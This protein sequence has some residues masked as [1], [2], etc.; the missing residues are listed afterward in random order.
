L[1]ICSTEEFLVDIFCERFVKLMKDTLYH[2]SKSKVRHDYMKDTSLRHQNLVR[3]Q[4]LR[5]NFFLKS[6]S[7]RRLS[8]TMHIL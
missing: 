7:F 5:S 2:E 4:R 1:P 8:P 6:S 3:F